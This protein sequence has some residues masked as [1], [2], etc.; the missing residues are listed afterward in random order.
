MTSKSLAKLKILPVN[1]T[2]V[3]YSPIEGKDVLVRTG[4]IA[5][6]SCFFHAILHSYSKEYSMMNKKERMK[7]V[8]KLRAGLSGKIDKKSWETMGDGNIAKIP[9][10]ENILEIL[11]S[12]YNFLKN[13]KNHIRGRNTRRIYKN[14]IGSD[15]EKLEVYQIIYEIIPLTTF[16]KFILPKAYKNTTNFSNYSQVI[17][18]EID[19]YISKNG[20]L[21]GVNSKQTKFIIS[22]IS[23][24]INLLCKE[25]YDSAFKNYVKGLENIGAYADNY[26]I[27]F[28]ADRFDRDIYFLDSNTRVPYNKCDTTDTLKGRKSIIIIWINKD[29]YEIVGRL[30][31][32]NRVQREFDSDDPLIQKL[33]MFLLEP[34]KIQKYYP[35]LKDY[36]PKLTNQ[37]DSDENLEYS[38]RRRSKCNSDNSSQ[39]DSDP[40]YD[41]SDDDSDDN[42]DDDSD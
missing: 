39:Q 35:E 40:Y 24:L 5:E 28:I 9:F 16:E 18:A 22:A 26:T 2:V 15:K 31:P 11:T 29:H 36:I 4:T 30:L 8:L 7:L 20:I 41:D 27:N 14:L 33:K 34:E 21:N 25:A 37:D 1:K 13:Q 10:Q 32:G 3:F 42:S 23:N 17:N 6:G 12:F 19:S 38:P